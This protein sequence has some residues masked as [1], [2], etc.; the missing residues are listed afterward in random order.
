[1]VA[2]RSDFSLVKRTLFY[3]VMLLFMTIKLELVVYGFLRVIV[4]GYSPSSLIESRNNI[5]DEDIT[6]VVNA[7]SLEV[8]HPYLG[9]VLKKK[10]NSKEL[11]SLM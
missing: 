1:M 7:P 10:K 8:L 11:N 2:N 3:V 4:N 5:V 6:S 9:F